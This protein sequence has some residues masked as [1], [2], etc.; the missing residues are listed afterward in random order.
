MAPRDPFGSSTPAP[1]G[2]TRFPSRHRTPA[3]GREPSPTRD[4]KEN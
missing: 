4:T 1:D 3:P 2:L